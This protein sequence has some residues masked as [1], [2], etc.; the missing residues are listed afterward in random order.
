MNGPKEHLMILDMIAEGK[1]TP[2]EA[3]ELFKAM[4]ETITDASDS[5]LP[6]LPTLPTPPF[7]PTLPQF[8]GS[9]NPTQG[10]SFKDLVSALRDADIDHI[11]ISDLQEMQNHN[12]TAEYVREMLALGLEPDGLGEWVNLR[13]HDITPRYVREQN[14]SR[15]S[16]KNS[17]SNDLTWTTL[18]ASA[19]MKY[20][21]WLMKM[22]VPSNWS[23]A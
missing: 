19:R 6:A 23:S 1:I 21:S 17:T 13:I 10:Q 12:L 2:A 14:L 7:P 9:T 3:E 16:K 15:N 5:P 4:N 18:L 22:S 11:T 8:P 20:T